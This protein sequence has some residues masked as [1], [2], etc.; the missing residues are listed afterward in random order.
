MKHEYTVE[1]LYHFTCGHCQMWWS[2]ASTPIT[3]CCDLL[4]LP[5]DEPAFCPHCGKKD[6]LKIKDKFE[7]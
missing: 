3:N 2:W 5:E 6:G 1:V 4:S 7:N